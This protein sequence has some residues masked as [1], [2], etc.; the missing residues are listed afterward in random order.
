MVRGSHAAYAPPR[1]YPG[2]VAP[3]TGHGSAEV[4]TLELT[5]GPPMVDNAEVVL[6][7]ELLGSSY[8]TIV[9]NSSHRD[10]ARDRWLRVVMRGK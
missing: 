7:D 1:D 4:N 2:P 8:E 9:T 5:K 6:C 10:F 3:T